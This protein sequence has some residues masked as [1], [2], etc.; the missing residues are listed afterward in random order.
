[1]NGNV[2]LR[3]GDI[4]QIHMGIK[5]KIEEEIKSKTATR[6]GKL[7]ELQN[8]E[9]PKSDDRSQQL[10]TR[11]ALNREVARLNEKL[12]GL[13]EAVDRIKNGVYGVCRRCEE[14]IPLERLKIVPEAT[15]CFDCADAQGRPH[16]VHL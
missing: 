5:L 7:I 6:N 8:L 12:V 2:A 13:Y 15:H 11:E 3:A 16:L 14:N 4:S 10:D 1:M 9:R